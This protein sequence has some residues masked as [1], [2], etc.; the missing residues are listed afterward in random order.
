MKRLFFLLLICASSL[1]SGGEVVELTDATFEH[2][3]QASS[4]GTTGSWFVLF[5]AKGC[6]HCAIM[7]DGF[8]LLAEEEELAEKG[9]VI[10]KVDT[11]SNRKTS[12]RFEI[13]GTPTLIYLHRGKLHRYRGKRTKDAMK[14]FLVGHSGE[15][16]KPIPVPP[17][18]IME[19]F[20]IGKAVWTEFYRSL[21]GKNGTAGI[22]VIFLTVMTFAV[23]T[24]LLC[25][26]VMPS[27]KSKQKES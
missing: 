3:T 26:L 11:P 23:F 14:E 21:A 16:G 22:A 4:G 17:T 18:F 27:T 24:L 15:G 5:S 20:L 9:I 19:L 7:E 1:V 2:Q 12:V 13:K 25:I 8:K 6:K 10:A